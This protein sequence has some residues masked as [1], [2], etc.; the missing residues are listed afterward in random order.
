MFR[1][2]F[3]RAHKTKSKKYLYVIGAVLGVAV[4]V[5]AVTSGIIYHQKQ[6]IVRQKQKLEAMR[7]TAEKIY[8]AMKSLEIQ[9]GQLE[10]IVLLNADAAQI[11]DLLEKRR[12]LGELS[13]QYDNFVSEIGVYKKAPVEK[14][15]IFKMARVFGECDVNVPEGFVDE[16][17]RYIAMWRSTGRLQTALNR[18]RSYGYVQTIG[19]A[20]KE[21]NL[22]KQ[23]L[24][25]ALREGEF[26][27]NA[28]GKIT[29]YGYAKGM[30]QF[31]PET[32][33]HYGLK[34]GPR[35]QEA[36]YDRV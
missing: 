4:I 29:R 5:A 11:E 31:I 27:P 32:A 30:W 26:F 24:F 15:V 25:L 2:A 6:V 10:D 12:Q 3:E 34:I 33:E 35:Y 36:V 21:N 18:A 8:Y 17:M 9:I 14:Q 13:T 7:N 22:P 16:V 23:F 28:V 1:R 20:L 19:K